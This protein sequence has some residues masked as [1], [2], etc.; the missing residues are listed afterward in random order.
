[1]STTLRD[2]LFSGIDVALPDYT[3]DQ[4]HRYNAILSTAVVEDVQSTVPKIEIISTG[5][6]GNSNVSRRFQIYLTKHVIIPPDS[7]RVLKNDA[8]LD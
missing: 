7:S 6:E 3:R 2:S 5:G 4:D 1:M 8:Q